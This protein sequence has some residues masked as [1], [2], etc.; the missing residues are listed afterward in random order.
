MVSAVRFQTAS[1]AAAQGVV[2]EPI[3]PS[4]AA[5]VLILHG[6]QG[7][8]DHVRSIVRRFAH[9]GFVSFAPDLYRGRVA[10]TPEE[11]ERL[12]HELDWDDALDRIDGAVR[13]LGTHPR[14]NGN[15]GIVGFGIGGALAF[16]AA[17]RIAG[18]SAA[19][20]FYGMP[21][22]GQAEL[23]RIR[24][25]VLAHV[26]TR[27][28]RVSVQLAHDIQRRVR[29]AGGEMDVCVYETGHAFLNETRSDAYDAVAATL[30]WDRTV[31][32]LREKLGESATAD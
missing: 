32:F 31:T 8:T 1:G 28:P 2:A 19:V 24:V 4:L 13:T 21:R 14:C 11:A 16:S 7:L 18:L 23:E 26:A 15:A 6:S 20:P 25:P 3:V 29:A 17:S 5:G 9:A 27:D 12:A 30:A 10:D 22:K